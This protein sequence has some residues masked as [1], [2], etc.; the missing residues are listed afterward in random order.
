LRFNRKG[1]VCFQRISNWARG[2][3]ILFYA[4]QAFEIKRQTT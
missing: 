4:S 3:P 2:R 1:L